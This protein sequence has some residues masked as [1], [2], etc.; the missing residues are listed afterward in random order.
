MLCTCTYNTHTCIRTHMYIRSLL[1]CLRRVT[2]HFPPPQTLLSLIAFYLHGTCAL[3]PKPCAMKDERDP[4]H[5]PRKC[6]QT[7]HATCTQHIC[8]QH[9]RV[10]ISDNSSQSHDVCATS[11]HGFLSNT[12]VAVS[13][14]L[15]QAVS[16]CTLVPK[17]P[18]YE[19]WTRC[20]RSHL[21]SPNTARDLHAVYVHAALHGDGTCDSLRDARHVCAP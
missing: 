8:V 6:P 15:L 9:C 7:L 5:T 4:L 1:V 20:H 21:A 3:C 11:M 17:A 18:R 10:L 2:S 12:H 19:R 16:L 13:A 14:V